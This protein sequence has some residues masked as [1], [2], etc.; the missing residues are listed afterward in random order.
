MKKSYTLKEI[1]KAIEVSTVTTSSGVIIDR[2][3]FWDVL[4]GVSRPKGPKKPP[5]R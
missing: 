2:Q 1:D 4:Q 5:L 3:K